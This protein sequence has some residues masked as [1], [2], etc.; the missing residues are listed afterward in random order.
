M[1]SS[2]QVYVHFRTRVFRRHKIL[3]LS[4]S[5]AFSLTHCVFKTKKEE[6]ED[7]REGKEAAGGR[8]QRRERS[9]QNKSPARSG[10]CSGRTQPWRTRW[11]RR[12]RERERE[13]IGG[14]GGERNSSG[15]ASESLCEE[16]KAPVRKQTYCSVGPLVMRPR[17]INYFPTSSDYYNTF[18][19][20][21][22][23]YFL[24]V[25]F[26]SNS[27]PPIVPLWRSTDHQLPIENR[28]SMLIQ[29]YI[30]KTNSEKKNSENSR[31]SMGI[32]F[33]YFLPT[34]IRFLL[35]PRGLWVMHNCVKSINRNYLLIAQIPNINKSLHFGPCY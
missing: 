30:E 34:N 15:E 1:K 22:Q 13:G 25:L 17:H 6:K 32:T 31:F 21:T 8:E 27:P 35:I 10:S 28:S 16:R 9:G 26:S 4:L 23:H 24:Y 14:E 3:S 18:Y 33:F 5:L 12:R 29:L 19:M 2:R 20:Y 7:G 11:W